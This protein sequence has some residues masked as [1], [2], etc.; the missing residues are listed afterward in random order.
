VRKATLVLCLLALASFSVA[1]VD[2]PIGT[3]VDEIVYFFE[4]DQSKVL[5]MMQSGDAQFF[6]NNF[7]A[8]RQGDIQASGLPWDVSYGSYNEYMLNP[9]GPICNDGSF[10]PFGI[11]EI[12][13]ALNWLIDRQYL[14]DEYLYGLGVPMYG[15][16]NPNFPTAGSIGPTERKL[17]ITYGPDEAKGIQ[18]IHDAMIAN[19]AELVD[20]KWYYGG[21]PVVIMGAI[22]TEDE[23]KQL[24]DYLCDRLE[25][26]GFTC[27]RHYGLNAELQAFWVSSDPWDNLWNFY[28]SGW[29]ANT[30]DRS[31]NSQHLGYDTPDGWGI[32]L[33]QA[34]VVPDEFYTL[35]QDFYFGNFANLD[36][37]AAMAAQLEEWEM[38]A[39]ISFHIWLYVQAGTWAWANDVTTTVGTTSGVMGN[40]FFSR[41]CRFVDEDGAPVVGGTILVADPG[42]F[43][44]PWNP[45][46]GSNWLYDAQIYD[47]CEDR[48]AYGDP[49]TGLYFPWLID[50]AVVEKNSDVIMFQ[51][52][53]WVT[54]TNN[55]NIVPPADAYYDWDAVAQRWITIGE[56]FPDGT[57]ARTTTTVTLRDDLYENK[58]HDGSNLSFA[59]FYFKYLLSAAR[60]KVDSPYY[61]SSTVSG[62]ETG[63]Q[64]NKGM[65]IL[66]T[67]PIVVQ[68]WDDLAYFDAEEQAYQFMYTFC[69]TWN[70]GSAPWHVMAAALIGE[71]K[72]E[73]AF[74][75]D[76]AEELEVNRVSF[77]AGPTLEL[78]KADARE[79]A[80]ENFVP[81]PS[82]LLKVMD[83]GEPYARFN[84]MIDFLDTYGH[85]WIGDGPMMVTSVDTVARQIVISRFADYRYTNEAFMQFATPRYADISLSGPDVIAAGDVASFD[86]TLTFQGE[87]YPMTDI[88]S[89]AWLIVDATGQVA[90]DGQGE[91]VADGAATITLPADVTAGL[92]EGSTT[93]EIVAVLVPVAKPSYGSTTFLVTQ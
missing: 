93:L 20:G 47:Q 11:G 63:L 73:F 68:F 13:Q 38:S 91:L 79:A 75:A 88:T 52:M 7:D 77:I 56:Q 37:R 83:P 6:G 50:H 59:D 60:A 26:A 28:T 43:V 24:G 62:Y 67:D 12:R 53:D 86:V 22:R 54:L 61:D 29:I 32:P 81:F 16:F 41:V 69:P 46:D 19:G 89:V 90:A 48:L 72:Q 1:A 9:A 57:T 27:D 49:Y 30:I 23:R 58:W 45:V 17:S 80:N 18:V 42:M 82:E 4:N 44:E 84:N 36:E 87:A 65:K 40:P 2:Y 31:E 10:N 64:T 85:L 34:Y 71:E 39:D 21:E 8:E 33:W 3:W 14:I 92:A 66:S 5:D 74:S 35:A 15:M 55:D 51:T 25:L 70:Y 76:K 78:L